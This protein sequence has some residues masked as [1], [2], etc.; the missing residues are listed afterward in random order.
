MSKS[1]P[2]EVRQIKAA[3]QL[4]NWTQEVLSQKSGVPIST[5]RR[6]ES[7]TDKI[8]G[9]YENIEKIFSAL[10]EGDENFSIEFMNSGEPGV[11]LRKKE[12]N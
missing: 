8:R 4:L 9:K 2:F 3:R 6:V 5:L 1:V 10:R 7:S 11:R 12:F